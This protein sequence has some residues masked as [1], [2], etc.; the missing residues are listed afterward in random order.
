MITI[1][2][3]NSRTISSMFMNNVTLADNIS[4][5]AS[6]SSFN[7]GSYNGQASSWTGSGLMNKPIGDFQIKNV[8]N[9]AGLNPNFA[10]SGV[11]LRIH[12]TLIPEPE[13]YALI[14]IPFALGS[15]ILRRHFQ[16]EKRQTPTTTL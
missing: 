7:Y 13:E 10:G 5:R 15:V 11:T 4:I 2:R 16:K 8:E 6:S 1:P 3:A 9:W 14:F 12:S